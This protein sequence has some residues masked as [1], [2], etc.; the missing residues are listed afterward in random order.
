VYMRS[1]AAGE[2]VLASL[3]R[4]LTQRLRLRVNR[5]KSGVARP[6]TRKFLGYSVTWDRAARLRVSPAAVKRLKTKLRGL[7]SR[8]RGRRLADVVADLNLA[9]RGW[10]VYFR[11]AEVKAS[12]EDFSTFCL[13]QSAK[14]MCCL[15]RLDIGR[16]RFF[17]ELGV[18]LRWQHC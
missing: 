9:T 18:N 8:G 2:R 10:V 3:E 4:W 16:S 13:D 15:D 6:W 11:L 17:K 7:L 5:D 12:F 1:K 14:G